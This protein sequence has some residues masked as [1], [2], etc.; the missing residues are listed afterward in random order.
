MD[1]VKTIKDFEKFK[2]YDRKVVEFKGSVKFEV[3]VVLG[4]GWS[5]KAG[6]FIE[7]GGSIEA[8]GFIFSFVFDIQCKW[9]STKTLP[10]WRK[11]WANMFPLRKW[12][13]DI[14]SEKCWNELRKLPTKEEQK[15]I[16]AWE[17]WHWILRGHLECFFGLK[18]KI[19]VEEVK[20]NEFQIS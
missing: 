14:L 8:G 20:N 2:N 3:D 15:V 19:Y 1:V 10:F 6:G 4:E 12:D 11:Y 5:I 13:R 7:A 9:F 16:C 17:G 18:D